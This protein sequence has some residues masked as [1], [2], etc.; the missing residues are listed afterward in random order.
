MSDWLADD[1]D[2]MADREWAHMERQFTVMGY[3]EGRDVGE[4]AKL[5]D[6]HIKKLQKIKAS[7]KSTLD[8]KPPKRYKHV[9]QN[10]RKAR[11]EE[12]RRSGG[13]DGFKELKTR[14]HHRGWW[15][16]SR[17]TTILA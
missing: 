2:G 10:A 9:Y 4:E 13:V 17:R 6:I 3:R 11:L 7:K 8:N 15:E 5:Q 14:T 12:E 16:I 1:D